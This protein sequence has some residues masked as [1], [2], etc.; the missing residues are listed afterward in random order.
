MGNSLIAF[1]SPSK[2]IL[3]LQVLHKTLTRLMYKM[4]VLDRLLSAPP[5]KKFEITNRSLFVSS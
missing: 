4:M 2:I 3:I 5:Q 1:D